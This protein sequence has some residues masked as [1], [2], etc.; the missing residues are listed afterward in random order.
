MRAS[1]V[2]IRRT[3]RGGGDA[4]MKPSSSGEFKG[5]FLYEHAT[6]VVQSLLLVSILGNGGL[7][8]SLFEH[9]R[10]LLAIWALIATLSLPRSVL[11]IILVVGRDQL[12][13]MNLSQ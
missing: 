4:G 5:G 6:L 2:R 9:G 12:V 11:A 13:F 3:N 8:I 1:S 7:A 10:P